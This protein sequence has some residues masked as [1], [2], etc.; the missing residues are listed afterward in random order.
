[1]NK[2]SV[3]RRLLYWMILSVCCLTLL[4][5]LHLQAAQS[6]TTTVTAKVAAQEE[7]PQEEPPDKLPGQTPSVFTG[8]RALV[9][10]LTILACLS[11]STAL[12]LSRKLY[13]Q[14]KKH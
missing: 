5:S 3:C 2:E 7:V 4:P 13:G 12:L 8:D 1:M 14:K 6:H 11:G 10:V 9:A